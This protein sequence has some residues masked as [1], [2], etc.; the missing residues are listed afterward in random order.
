MV[1]LR[2]KMSKDPIVQVIQKAVLDQFEDVRDLSDINQGGGKV[3][4]E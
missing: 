4:A 1:L 3:G 2:K